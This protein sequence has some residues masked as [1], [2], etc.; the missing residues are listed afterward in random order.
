MS[1]NAHVRLAELRKRLTQKGLTP[2]GSV[3]DR[4]EVTERMSRRIKHT[5][6]KSAPNMTANRG[7]MRTIELIVRSYLVLM[8]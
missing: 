5:L 3:D 1:R 8:L 2:V 7:E 4:T 6:K